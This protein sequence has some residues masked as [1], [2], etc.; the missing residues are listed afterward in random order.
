MAYSTVCASDTTFKTAHVEIDP[1]IANPQPIP[2]TFSPNG[3]E[4]NDYFQLT[5]FDINDPSTKYD[6][7]CFDEMVVTIFNRWG[8]K[9]FES[10]DPGFKWDGTKDGNGSSMCKPGS[11]MVII[12]GTFGFLST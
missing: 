6:D 2:N 4:V 3:D 12:K 10:T 5:P 8:Q 11:Y 9:V 1:P 7:P